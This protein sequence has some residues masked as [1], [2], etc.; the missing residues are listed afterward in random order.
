MNVIQISAESDIDIINMKSQLEH[1]IQIQETKESG[2][3]F[4]KI[5]SMKKYFYKIG[6]LKGSSFVKLPLRSSALI[7]IKKNDNFCFMWSIL[8]SLHPC[9]NDHPNRV[10]TY[11]QYFL[12]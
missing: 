11:I 2:S 12:K 7:I 1:Q 10:S 9:E 5:N 8:V 3:I 6:E 4:D